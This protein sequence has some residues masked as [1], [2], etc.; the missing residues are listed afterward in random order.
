MVMT[1]ARNKSED[2]VRAFDLGANDYVTKPV[3]LD[4]LLARGPEPA[5]LQD[6]GQQ[7]EIC[8]TRSRPR[9]SGHGA[10]LADQFRSRT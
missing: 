1:T 7:A 6:A 9:R 8:L 2:V 4:V 5:A 3:D 10:V